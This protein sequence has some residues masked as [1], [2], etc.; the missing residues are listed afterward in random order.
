M[1]IKYAI[2]FSFLMVTMSNCYKDDISILYSR[3][4]ELEERLKV[5]EE[6]VSDIN[7]EITTIW[8][9]LNAGD[10][11]LSVEDLPDGSGFKITFL[12]AGVKIIKHGVTPTVGENGNWWIGD[13]DTGIKAEGKD[14]IT[15]VIGVA[16]DPS[17]PSDNNYYW[18]K[19]LGAAPATFIL[20]ST[21]KKIRAN[22]S[23]GQG[24]QS[25]RTGQSGETPVVSIAMDT[26]GEYYWKIKPN[27]SS[28]ADWIRDQNGQKIPAHGQKGDSFFKSVDTSNPDYVIFTLADNST[29]K[30]GIYKELFIN[31]TDASDNPVTAPVMLNFGTTTVIKYTCTPNADVV[32]VNKP[33]GWRASITTM[34]KAAG[35]GQ[36]TIVAPVNGTGYN[37]SAGEIV[38]MVTN[39][40]NISIPGVINVTG[41]L[42]AYKIE[43]PAAW[44]NITAS[45][46]FDAFAGTRTYI[47]YDPED[48]ETNPA[49]KRRLAEIDLEYIIGYDGATE[50]PAVVVYEMDYTLNPKG[51]RKNTGII[52]ANGKPVDWNQIS[53]TDYSGIYNSSAASVTAPFSELYYVSGTGIQYTDP[54]V[55]TTPLVPVAY[56]FKDWE[57]NEY[58][59]GKIGLQ[60]YMLKGLKAKTYNDNTSIPTNMDRAQWIATT[61]GACCIFGY[62]DANDNTSGALS[63]ADTH[64]LLYNWYTG[65]SGKLDY[66]GWTVPE[67][68]EFQTLLDYAASGA[69]PPGRLRAVG[70]TYWDNGSS[71]ITN[72]TGFTG[73]GTGYRDKSNGS[74]G[75]GMDKW[76]GAMW[77]KTDESPWLPILRF[78]AFSVNPD[79]NGPETKTDGYTVRLVTTQLF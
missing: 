28:P 33:D 78:T 18:T 64:G 51:V 63:S 74:T 3:Q 37:E 4:Y 21:G 41:E 22:A 62:Q 24:G 53:G 39:S 19:Q 26:D 23:D 77:T 46:V 70:T 1:K 73:L 66:A 79:M 58:P 11:V 44:Q 69:N 31:F 60:Y 13:K 40:K 35:T 27:S 32:L 67:K 16:K 9:I 29:F 7:T 68:N 72:I 14:G 5:L 8:N 59:V 34:D 45:S 76:F 42:K 75:F 65:A 15:P 52:A 50:K 25:G 38:L 43:I 47:V 30:V 61:S 54:G 55:A 6:T 17:D 71:N 12:N 36:V 56:L 10:H 48:T 49:L 2:M 20:D 57:G